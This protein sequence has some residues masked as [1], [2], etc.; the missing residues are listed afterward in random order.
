MPQKRVA[1]TLLI[2]A[3]G[4]FLGYG[5][6]E[7]ADIVKRLDSRLTIPTDGPDRWDLGDLEGWRA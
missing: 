1:A 2:H 6:E 3:D 5:A 7:H 4:T